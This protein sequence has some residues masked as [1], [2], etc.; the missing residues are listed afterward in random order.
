M[1]ANRSLDVLLTKKTFVSFQSFLQVPKSNIHFANV[2]VH[3]RDVDERR[4]YVGV[5]RTAR[6]IQKDQRAGHVTERKLSLIQSM[7]KQ[8][9]VPVTGKQRNTQPT[10]SVTFPGTFKENTE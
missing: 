2:L 7:I 1:V 3:H 4:C 8:G 6:N 10:Q 9:H 5:V